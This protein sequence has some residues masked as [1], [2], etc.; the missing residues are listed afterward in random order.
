MEMHLEEIVMKVG[1]IIPQYNLWK[2]MTLPCL[3]SIKKYTD[4]SHLYIYLADNASQDVSSSEMLQTGKNLFDEHFQ[5]IRNK[6]NRG[7]A[8]ACNQGAELAREQ[9]CDSLLFLNNDTVVT[10]N[11][12]PPLLKELDNPEI[13][14][15][16]PLLLYPDNT[17]QHCGIIYDLN[18]YIGHIYSKFPVNHPVIRKHTFNRAITGAALLVRT[19]EF[20]ACGK[21]CEAYINGFEDVDLCFQYAKAGYRCKVVH[22]SIVY[23]YESKTPGRIN[24]ERGKHNRGLLFER[25]K[26]IVPYAHIFYE[27]DGYVPALTNDYFFYVR[28]NEEKS[29]E[30]KKKIQSNYSDELC[31]QILMEEPYWHEGYFVLFDSFYKQKLYEDALAVCQLALSFR[32]FFPEIYDRQLECYKKMLNSAEA[33]QL[34]KEF[35]QLKEMRNKGKLKNQERLKLLDDEEWRRKFYLTRKLPIFSEE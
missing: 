2:E 22:E 23:H 29:I 6:E 3:S 8:A 33:R 1:I 31:R 34:V 5:Y 16:G 32:Y 12:L 19:A 20:F 25:N 17:I 4:L 7:F 13:G 9:G 18:G 35:A 24:P 27:Q 15:V 14:L 26:E 11:W 10:E 28:L 21:F 30:Y